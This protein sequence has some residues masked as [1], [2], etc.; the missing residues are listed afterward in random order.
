MFFILSAIPAVQRISPTLTLPTP[1]SPT[2]DQCVSFRL[3]PK[4]LFLQ[5]SMSRYT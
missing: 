1:I 2:K 3:L 5:V 4:K